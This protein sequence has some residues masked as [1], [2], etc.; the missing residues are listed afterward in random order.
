MDSATATP[1]AAGASA[2]V[3]RCAKGVSE[4]DTDAVYVRVADEYFLNVVQKQV[5]KANHRVKYI[6]ENIQN[7]SDVSPLYPAISALRIIFD[8][9]GVQHRTVAVWRVWKR[10]LAA[11]PERQAALDKDLGGNVDHSAR[12]MVVLTPPVAVF[13]KEEA[14]AAPC[15]PTGWRCVKDFRK[16]WIKVVGERVAPTWV[17]TDLANLELHARTALVGVPFF[18]SSPDVVDSMVYTPQY[19]TEP[20][21]MKVRSTRNAMASDAEMFEITM[22]FD[23]RA[24]KSW[25]E[26]RD[27]IVSVAQA[28]PNK[29]MVDAIS[30]NM[31]V[32][33]KERQ[34]QCARQGAQLAK[35]ARREALHNSSAA[36]TGAGLL[37]DE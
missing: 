26:L 21:G 27:S 32:V 8:K 19:H 24:S 3:V 14:L 12:H 16:G 11:T 23:T 13:T 22:E 30:K 15:G 33:E 34:A 6:M 4:T 31:S 35:A 37:K 25:I 1:T 18:T 36:A 17:V 9:L 29:E 5:A 20:V 7:A 28:E 2:F 10:M